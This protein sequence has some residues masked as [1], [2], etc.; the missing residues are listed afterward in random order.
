MVHVTTGTAR[1][2]ANLSSASF[3]A[4]G[5]GA[6]VDKSETERLKSKPYFVL[7]SSE[8]HVHLASLGLP[9]MGDSFTLALCYLCT[10]MGS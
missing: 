3:P 9:A 2:E 1:S 4:C 7:T 10:T 6:R 8:S 5:S